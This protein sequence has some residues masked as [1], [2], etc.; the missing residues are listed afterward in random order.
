MQVGRS[1]SLRGAIAVTITCTL[2]TGT[3]GTAI[4]LAPPTAAAPVGAGFVINEGD[5]RFI[6]KQIRISEAHATKEGAAPGT[7]VPGTSVIGTGATDVPDPMLPWGLRQVDGRNNNIAHPAWGAA[8]TAFPRIGP[9]RWDR[10]DG[11]GASVS[12]NPSARPTNVSDTGP[13]VISN[14]IVD[15]SPTNPAAVAAAGPGAVP[16]QSKSFFIPNVAPDA[17]LS[18]PY[19]SMFTLF[20]QFFDHGLDF[21]SKTDDAVLIPLRSDDPLWNLTPPSRRS[22]W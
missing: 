14:L 10:F 8:D 4:A 7:I 13:R 18:A 3:I 20:G 11:S 22:C 15:Q 2:A 17:G 6:L 21:T 9:A 19:N 16:D 1:G 5:L 12:Y